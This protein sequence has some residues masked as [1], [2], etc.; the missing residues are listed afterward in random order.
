MPIAGCSPT[1][2]IDHEGYLPSF[3][4]II[5][6]KTVTR[7]ITAMPRSVPMPTISALECGSPVSWVR[8]PLVTV[9]FPELRERVE[10]LGLEFFDVDLRWG[11]PDQAD[12]VLSRSLIR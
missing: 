8:T 3:P 1:R 11:V 5:T 6:G 4:V 12:A 10:Q 9:V 7:R 2:A